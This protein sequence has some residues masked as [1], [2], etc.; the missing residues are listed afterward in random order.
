MI[1]YKEWKQQIQ[2]DEISMRGPR[3]AQELEA[4]V[5]DLERKVD[6]LMDI[7]SPDLRAT[8]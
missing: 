3:G 4:R 7:V 2:E 5:Q 6:A 8:G 1:N